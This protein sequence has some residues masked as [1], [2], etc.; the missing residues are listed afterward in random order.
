[1]ESRDTAVPSPYY[2]VYF[3][4]GNL[5]FVAKMLCPYR[6]MGKNDLHPKPSLC[7]GVFVVDLISLP[8]G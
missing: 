6:D 3:I 4:N 5:I 2:R 1:M 7:L 8:P